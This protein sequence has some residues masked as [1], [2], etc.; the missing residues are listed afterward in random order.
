M[1]LPCPLGSPTATL[2][3]GPV[4]AEWNIPGNPV[5][6]SFSGTRHRICRKDEVDRTISRGRA[7][8][9]NKAAIG[10]LGLFCLV[11]AASLLGRT[12]WWFDLL[13]HFR[14]QLVV[15]GVSL[16]LILAARR[17]W[18][19]GAIAAAMAFANAVPINL[20]RARDRQSDQHRHGDDHRREVV[21][22]L[23]LGDREGRK[24]HD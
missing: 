22:E 21:G 23:G 4:R 18:I 2:P 3:I 8:E 24:G 15:A 11:S 12:V 16:A 19:G 13:T 6:S 1:S 7:R 17:R 9:L 10:G 20:Q 14:L 5:S